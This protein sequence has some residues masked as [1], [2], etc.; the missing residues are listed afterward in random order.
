MVGKSLIFNGDTFYCFGPL[1]I[2]YLGHLLVKASQERSAESWGGLE[3]RRH[4]AGQHLGLGLKLPQGRPQD[5]VCTRRGCQV[6]R[7]QSNF[8]F[9]VKYLRTKFICFVTVFMNFLKVKHKTLFPIVETATKNL[10][11]RVTNFVYRIKLFSNFSQTCAQRPP[12]GPVVRFW[13][14]AVG[15][16][17]LF[18]FSLTGLWPVIV[19]MWSLSGGGRYHWFYCNC[20]VSEK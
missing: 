11:I 20:I 13:F 10:D 1:L 4:L 12:F 8:I 16:S 18:Y 19:D 7:H 17:I 6:S 3:R 15:C 2:R 5:P 9:L 14:F